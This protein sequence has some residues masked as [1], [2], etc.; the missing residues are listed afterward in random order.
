[1]KTTMKSFGLSSLRSTCGSL[2]RLSPSLFSF[3]HLVIFIN[4]FY[5]YNKVRNT[6]FYILNHHICKNYPWYTGSVS[7]LKGR[8]FGWC[9]RS[10]GPQA[11]GIHLIHINNINNI[12]LLYLCVWFEE[13]VLYVYIN[14]LLIIIIIIYIIIIIIIISL[15]SELNGLIR[16]YLI[17]YKLIIIITSIRNIVILSNLYDKPMINQLI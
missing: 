7:D 14:F 2:S 4:I 13:R 5:L 6:G 16:C 17:L 10:G 3:F 1:M 9:D 12:K 15:L 11:V 8:G